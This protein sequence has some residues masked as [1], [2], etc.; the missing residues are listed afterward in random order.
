MA[1]MRAATAALGCGG[2]RRLWAVL[3]VDSTV[4]LKKCCYRSNGGREPTVT[5][6]ALGRNVSFELPEFMKVHRSMLFV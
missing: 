4:L 5:D 1:A 2:Q 3:V 6:A